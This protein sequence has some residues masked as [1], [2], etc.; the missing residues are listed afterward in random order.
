MKHLLTTC[1]AALLFAGTLSAKE[2]V[3][4]NGAKPGVWTMDLRAAVKVAAEKKLPIFI[5]FTGSDWCGWCIHMDEKVFGQ[6]EWKTYAQENLMLVW[7]DFP[8]D[9]KLVPSKYVERNKKLAKDNGV[10]G[11][12]TYIVLKSDGKTTLGK[13]GASRDATPANFIE[14][15]KGV[16]AKGEPKK[17]AKPEEAKPEEVQPEA[18]APEE[19]D[20]E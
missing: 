5:N 17:D 15:V 9:K 13:L 14:K 10:T 12:P 20:A 7:I 3:E 6:P 4:I 19:T 2:K 16:I 1:C 11:Y 18:P 8:R